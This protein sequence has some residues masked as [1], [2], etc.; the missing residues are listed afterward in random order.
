MIRTFFII[1]IAAL[2]IYPAV[3]F[4][5]SYNIGHLPY[6]NVLFLLFVS[7]LFLSIRILSYMVVK[8]NNELIK[9]ITGYLIALFP[10]IFPLSGV[11]ISSIMDDKRQVIPYILFQGY[12]LFRFL[13]ILKQMEVNYHV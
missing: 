1:N 11:A 12:Y 10:I 13:P 6:L 5:I 8:I 9:N 7:L 4:K 3:F 2:L